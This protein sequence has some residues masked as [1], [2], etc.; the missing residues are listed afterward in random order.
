MS[1]ITREIQKIDL[2]ADRLSEH[3]NNDIANILT[4]NGYEVV[5]KDYSRPWGGF[6]QLNN[7]NAESFLRDFFSDTE[8]SEA[9]LTYG[10][11]LSPKIL[12]V[13]P[14]CRL[15]WQYHNRRAESWAYL[16]DGAYYKS[17]N[18][19]QGEQQAAKSGD[20]VQFSKSERHRLVG[21]AG[22]YTLVAEIWQH[23][24]PDNLSDESDII[25]LQDD[26]SRR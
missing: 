16:T 12:V 17:L 19:D 23:V 14:G 2:S 24:Y 26:Y 8:L 4:H 1:D 5:I 13:K 21:A 10:A 6:N 25:R 11:P 7:N 20:V 22:H 9:Q 3:V 15:S 18:N